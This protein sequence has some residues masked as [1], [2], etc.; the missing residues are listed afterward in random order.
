MEE[1]EDPVFK[2]ME[3]TKTTID[4]AMKTIEECKGD[5]AEAIKCISETKVNNQKYKYS[6]EEEKEKK[7][8]N[9]K[10]INEL[11]NIV[12]AAYSN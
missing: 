8:R 9:L 2:V 6:S 3:T 12:N 5:V 11:R 7:E 10:K 4:I 1:T